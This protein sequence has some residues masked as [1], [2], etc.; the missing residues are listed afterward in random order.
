[1]SELTQERIEPRSSSVTTRRDFLRRTALIAPAIPFAVA[2]LGCESD[3]RLR[4][5]RPGETSRLA[6]R[7]TL[8]ADTLTPDELMALSTNS[9]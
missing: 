5:K 6:R 4:I 7:I 3:N 8:P 2:S 1:M 9:I